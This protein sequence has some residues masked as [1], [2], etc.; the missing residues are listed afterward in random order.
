MKRT[1][2][3]GTREKNAIL[4]C[5][6]K[7][8]INYEQEIAEEYGLSYLLGKMSERMRAIPSLDPLIANR[9]FEKII[10]YSIYGIHMGNQRELKEIKDNGETKRVD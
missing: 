6:R 8:P 1:I 10:Q 5:V 7:E 3:L 2:G 9:C 4:A